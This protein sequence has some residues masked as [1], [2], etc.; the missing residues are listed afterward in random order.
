MDR[1][2]TVRPTYAR[3]LLWMVLRR[4]PARLLLLPFSA[5]AGLGYLLRIL[6]RESLKQVNQRLLLGT[7]R[8]A[9]LAKPISAYADF[10][11]A[12]NIC[13]G[14]LAQIAADRAAGYRIIIATASYRLYVEAIADRLGIADVIATDLHVS[15]GTVQAS[16]AGHNCY[17]PHKAQMIAAWMAQNGLSRAECH[18]RCYSDHVSDIPMLEMADEAFVT[19]AHLPMRVVAKEKGWPELDWPEGPAK[20]AVASPGNSR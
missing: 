9:A 5:L 2:I 17:G 16:I 20:A 8:L 10:V 12:R 1:T 7:P 14:A 3:F 6:D 4:N 19:N 11:V 15:N 13:P 18:I